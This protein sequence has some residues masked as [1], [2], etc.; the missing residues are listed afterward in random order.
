MPRSVIWECVRCA[1][2]ALILCQISSNLAR[3]HLKTYGPA[4]FVPLPPGPAPAS[5]ANVNQR[6]IPPPAIVPEQPIF[7]DHDVYGFGADALADYGPGNVAD[8]ENREDPPDA[9]NNNAP[10]LPSDT[11]YTTIEIPDGPCP[12]EDI[13]PQDVGSV[14]P[15]AFRDQE[16]SHIRMAYL[17]AVINNVY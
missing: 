4:R 9:A 16:P 7:A 8:E 3:K 14:L 10:A 6:V 2:K 1:P 12:N 17:Q 15:P 5:Q 13:D 11:A